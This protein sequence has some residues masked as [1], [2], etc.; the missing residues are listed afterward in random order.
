[1]LLLYSVY[2][3]FLQPNKSCG[4]MAHWY[5]EHWLMAKSFGSLRRLTWVD[6][7]WKCQNF[8]LFPKCFKES[9][10]L[11]VFKVR[12]VRLRIR[13]PKILHWPFP[14]QTLVFMCLH[15][16]LLKTP[17]E[18]EKLGKG[19]IALSTLLENFLPLSSNTKLSSANYFNL[20]EYKICRSGMS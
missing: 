13:I 8:L 17:W 4:S 7:F 9:F 2:F 1:M 20:E 10:S 18:K 3:Q 19:E 16:S 11:S 6:T 5:A 15:T 12:L 14:K